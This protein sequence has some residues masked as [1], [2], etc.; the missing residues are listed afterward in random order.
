MPHPSVAVAMWNSSTLDEDRGDHKIHKYVGTQGRFIIVLYL[1][2]ELKY[3]DHKDHNKR[4][5]FDDPLA[6]VMIQNVVRKANMMVKPV[7]D[8]WFLLSNEVA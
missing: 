8:A 3:Q 5:F 4:L 7:K 6:M 2:M 1:F